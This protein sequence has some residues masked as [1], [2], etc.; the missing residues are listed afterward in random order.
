MEDKKMLSIIKEDGTTEEVELVIAFE[1]DDDNKDYVVY[2]KN[3]TDKKGE[4]ENTTLY[5]LYCSSLDFSGDI[6]QMHSIYD[7]DDWDKVKYALRQLAAKDIEDYNFKQIQIN[8]VIDNQ[9]DDLPRKIRER[10]ESKTNTMAHM[11]NVL[12][13]TKENKT[14]PEITMKNDN[15]EANA[16]IENNNDD[17]KVDDIVKSV[18]DNITE[19]N[20]EYDINTPITTEEAKIEE[21][22]PVE[23]V[24][25]A[26]S[27]PVS[28]VNT[29]NAIDFDDIVNLVD[30]LKQAKEEENQEKIRAEET[31]VRYEQSAGELNMTTQEYQNLKDSLQRNI[32]ESIQRKN[33]YAETS[34]II[35]QKTADNIKKTTELK[36]KISYIKS[37]EDWEKEEN[38]ENDYQTLKKVA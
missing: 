9:I 7:E 3:E 38:Q 21:N 5:I 8:K 16:E 13:K 37:L 25:E 19:N 30:K 6:P 34:S 1:F 31:R 32:D 22:T 10:E 36:E 24:V 17:K 15:I 4:N 20:N 29:D 26:N 11:K 23:N 33:Q 18:F 2:T 28:F 12:V 14:E 35:E 27:I